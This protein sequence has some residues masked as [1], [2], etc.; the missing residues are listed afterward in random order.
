MK[1][2]KCTCDKCHKS[3]GETFGKMYFRSIGGKYLYLCS[4][5]WDEYNLL[6]GIN[7]NK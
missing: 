7:R 6:I 2:S 4:I 1:T 3:G 5:C